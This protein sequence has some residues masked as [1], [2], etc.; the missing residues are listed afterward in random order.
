M[1]KTISIWEHVKRIV[2][3]SFNLET[4]GEIREHIERARE[5]E[6]QNHL[7]LQHQ[8]HIQHLMLEY[9]EQI[10]A[11][12]EERRERMVLESSLEDER[13]A[14]AKHKKEMEERVRLHRSNRPLQEE[15]V[16]RQ[17]KDVTDEITIIKEAQE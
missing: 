17:R 16:Y 5:E 4:K 7:R 3:H 1:K 6:M 11:Y 9:H 12:E 8:K 14:Q 15:V 2:A 13:I 10:L